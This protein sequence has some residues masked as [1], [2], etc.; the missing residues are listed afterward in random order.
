MIQLGQPDEVAARLRPVVHHPGWA[1]LY[2]QYFSIKAQV[3][4]GRITLLGATGTLNDWQSPVIKAG[5]P[6]ALLDL[7]GS[8]GCLVGA[9]PANI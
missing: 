4:G 7:S 2:V 5:N 9:I 8:R 6:M 1:G 3:M